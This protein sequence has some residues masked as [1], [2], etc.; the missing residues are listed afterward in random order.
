MRGA[1]VGGGGAGFSVV[2]AIFCF[3]AGGCPSAVCVTTRG[4]SP[5]LLLFAGV[6]DT[7]EDAV[8]TAV[9]GL[10]FTG[11]G[12]SGSLS[13][14]PLVGIVTMGRRLGLRVSA[15]R[16]RTGEGEGVACGVALVPKRAF[17]HSSRRAASSPAAELPGETS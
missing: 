7:A 16:F 13:E 8:F 2:C 3:E 6:S 4:E 12:T 17:S 5:E 11:A 15:K 10:L 9:G 14:F 1:G